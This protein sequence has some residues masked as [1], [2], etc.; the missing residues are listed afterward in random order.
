VVQAGQAD[1]V[2]QV[3]LTVPSFLFALADRRLQETLVGLPDLEGLVVLFV[4]GSL[5]V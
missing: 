1:L 3:G 4:L 2:D 5:L